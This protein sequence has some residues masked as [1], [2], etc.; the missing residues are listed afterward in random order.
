MTA[1]M[2]GE[3]LFNLLLRLRLDIVGEPA[4]ESIFSILLTRVEDRII[5]TR[6]SNNPSPV[7]AQLG[8][9]NHT[10]SLSW[11]NWSLSVT[12]W[13]VIAVKKVYF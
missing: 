9:T 8:T 1:D 5:H 2:S 3:H 7:V 6:P 13:G 12:S 11:V 4:L 10:L